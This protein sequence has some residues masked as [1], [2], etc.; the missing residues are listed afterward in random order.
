M[1]K[2]GLTNNGKM[3]L[4]DLKQIPPNFQRLRAELN[5]GNDTGEDVSMAVTQYLED[6]FDEQMQADY[7]SKKTLEP[8]VMPGFHSTYVFDIVRFLLD[9]GL[10]PN[11]I[12]ED[13]NMM[14][15]L[16]YFDNGCLGADTLRL[17]L[18][19]GGDINLMIDGQTLF[20]SVDFD[21]MFDAL[22]Q[23][24]RR[25]FDAL[26]HYWFVLLGYGAKLQDGG[27]PIDTFDSFD[28]GKLRDHQEYTFFRKG[29]HS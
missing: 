5:S 22:N 26:V 28:I 11:A 19:H 2:L 8:V 21:V 17:L 7:R 14:L 16:K 23:E 4:D 20:C 15:E 6:C 1:I 29:F 9:Y 18:E 13:S 12:Y 3:I 10:N 24:D 27:N 25:R